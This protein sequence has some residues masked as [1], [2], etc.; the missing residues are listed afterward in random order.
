VYLLA[1]S[2]DH[3]GE[4]A[5][6]LHIVWVAGR[7]RFGLL[8]RWGRRNYSLDRGRAEVD[9]FGHPVPQEGHKPNSVAAATLA[10]NLCAQL[11][12]ARR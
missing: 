5:H 8:Q 9:P 10:E 4:Q 1:L 3:A 12:I 11:L 2:K 6:Q 7:I